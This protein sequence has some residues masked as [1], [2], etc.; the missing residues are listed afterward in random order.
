MLVSSDNIC[1]FFSFDQRKKAW[2]YF[3]YENGTSQWEHPLDSVYRDLVQ[4]TRQES[5]SSGADDISSIRDDLKSLD[6]N[7]IYS[8]A[9]LRRATNQLVRLI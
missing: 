1:C 8:G 2:Y 3:N 5:L 6:E 7:T 9:L 4:K